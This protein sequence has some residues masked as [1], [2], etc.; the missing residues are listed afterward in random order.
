MIYK[1][2]IK[3]F[4][5]FFLQFSHEKVVNL[6]VGLANVSF[7]EYQ[8]EHLFKINL[9][10][11]MAD[12]QSELVPQSGRVSETTGRAGTVREVCRSVP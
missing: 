3:Q 2:V 12:F 6:G 5:L 9:M 10:P 7:Y 11:S 1:F 4:Y 8:R